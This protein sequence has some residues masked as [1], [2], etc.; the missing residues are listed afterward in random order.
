VIFG[1]RLCRFPC[2]KPPAFRWQLITRRGFASGG[3]AAKKV[4]RMTESQ[5]LSAREAAKPRQ[6]FRTGGGKAA[7]A[8]PHRRR[9]SRASLFAREAAKP[10][11]LFDF[12]FCDTRL[13]VLHF[14]RESCALVTVCLLPLVVTFRVPR[15]SHRWSTQ[16]CRSS[17]AVPN[18]L[19]SSHQL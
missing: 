2:G 8:F 4:A 7:Q 18:T 19:S 10:R 5:R 17:C 6:P 9:Q 16:R 1:L 11:R 14:V 15:Q 12:R 13:V 3:V